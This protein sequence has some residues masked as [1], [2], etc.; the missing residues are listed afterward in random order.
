V[1]DLKFTTGETIANDKP[2]AIVE[3]TL[4]I[5]LLAGKNE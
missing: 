1:G 4:G 2:S 3:F 5:S